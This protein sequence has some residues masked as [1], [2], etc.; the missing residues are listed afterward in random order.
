MILNVYN[1]NAPI[2]ETRHILNYV[3]SANLTNVNTRHK[4]LIWHDVITKQNYFSNNGELFIQDERPA[5]DAP[6]SV[7]SSGIF[8]PYVE[9]QHIVIIS[10]KHYI[11]GYY[12]YADNA[13]IVYHSSQT[14]IHSMPTDF[15]S[16]HPKHYFTAEKKVTIQSTT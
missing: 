8:L 14:N 16:I 11:T 5:M 4:L 10:T 7:S 6:F 15:N 3:T 2:S 13:L 12:S 9:C 1:T